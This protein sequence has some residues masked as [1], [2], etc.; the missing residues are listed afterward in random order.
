MRLKATTAPGKARSSDVRAM[1]NRIARRYDL[2]NRLM[3]F[4]QDLRWRRDLIRKV[5]LESGAR[6]LDVGA[7]TGDLALEA[8]RQQPSA[9]VVAADFSRE[10]ISMGRR[11]PGAGRIA[12]VVSDAHQLPFAAGTFAAVVSGFLLRNV[13]DLPAALR[14]QRRVLRPGGRLAALDTSPPPPGFLQ[15][16][17]NLHLHRVIPLLGRLATGH[18]D[19]Y[20]YLPRST[21]EFH[22]PGALAELLRAA[23]FAGVT[24]ALRMFGTV[25]LHTGIRPAEGA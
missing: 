23:G 16:W 25:A 15:P 11:R 2:M 7:G 14:E 21:A 10:M 19:A 3:T 1:F 13:S 12:W 17:L 8:L 24:H 6:I 4:G 22:T 20:R 18:A 9:R 5:P